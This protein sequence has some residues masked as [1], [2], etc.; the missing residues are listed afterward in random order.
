MPT[1][2][3]AT[4][5]FLAR[6]RIAVTAISREPGNHGSEVVYSRLSELGYKSIAINTTAGRG[7]REI[8]SNALLGAAP[9]GVDAVVVGRRPETAE[10]TMD[11]CVDLVVEHG[12]MHR[13]LGA[14]S[15]L[16]EAAEYG[17]AHGITVSTAAAR[18]C[19]SRRPTSGARSYGLV[20]TL[21]GNVPK[22]V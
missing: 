21:S 17:R 16:E 5:E 3:E 9:G 20:F 19:S 22:E 11:E 4:A 2:G 1:I 14:G 18:S 13:G 8:L 12:W 15:V 10:E 6:R 7:S